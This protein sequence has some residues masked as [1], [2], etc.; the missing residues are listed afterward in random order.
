MLEKFNQAIKTSLD[1][2][3]SE[4]GIAP[5]QARGTDILDNLGGYGKS[6]AAAFPIPTSPKD[7]PGGRACRGQTKMGP[8][9]LPYSEHFQN[10][11]DSK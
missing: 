4:I 8:M 11:G 9:S 3:M 10:V 1:V 6:G 7:D 5:R 2:P